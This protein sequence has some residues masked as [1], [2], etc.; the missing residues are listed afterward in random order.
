MGIKGILKLLG[1][2]KDQVVDVEGILRGRIVSLEAAGWLHRAVHSATGK[3]PA[4]QEVFAK[5]MRKDGR[6]PRLVLE[7]CAERFCENLELLLEVVAH[8]YLV[9]EGNFDPKKE[10]PAGQQRAAQGTRALE[11][12]DFAKAQGVTDCLVR[13]IIARMGEEDFRERVTVVFAP[14]EGE[15]QVW[16]STFLICPHPD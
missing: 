8:V 1:V 6:I 14:A 10:G 12:R 15:A 2:T 16:L 11:K 5:H 7:K 9:M 3:D 4:R 13:I